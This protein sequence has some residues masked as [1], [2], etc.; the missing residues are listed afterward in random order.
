MKEFTTALQDR[1][2]SSATLVHN[3]ETLNLSVQLAKQDDSKQKTKL[4]RSCDGECYFLFWRHIIDLKNI[5]KVS[6]T[7]N[8]LD[9]GHAGRRGP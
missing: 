7:A 8:I 5:V 9:F 6:N 2:F 1:L 3:S 4:I